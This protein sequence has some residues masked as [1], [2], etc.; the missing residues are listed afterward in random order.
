M[1][2]RAWR[3]S[4]PRVGPRASRRLSKAGLAEPLRVTHHELQAH[5]K[6]HRTTGTGV[7]SD[8]LAMERLLG[9]ADA[10]APWHLGPMRLLVHWQSSRA[11]RV[12]LRLRLRHQSRWQSKSLAPCPQSTWCQEPPSAPG[13]PSRTPRTWPSKWNEGS[14]LLPLAAPFRR[15]S[16]WPGPQ[17]PLYR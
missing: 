11:P 17:G 3:I 5:V 4:R 12:R 8:R 1:V 14:P 16:A 7:A 13:Q 10:R 2:L 9:R 15:H 6:Q